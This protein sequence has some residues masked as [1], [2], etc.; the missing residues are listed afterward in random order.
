MKTKEIIINRTFDAPRELIWKAWTNPELAMRW[1]GP[2]DFTAPFIKVDLRIGGR[3]LFCMRSPEGKDYWST[4][5]YRELSEP[6]RI[7]CTDSFADSKGNIVPASYYGINEDFPLELD[8]TMTLEEN[9]GKTNMTLRHEGI[10]LGTMN[11][12]TEHG[13]EESFDKLKDSLV[14]S[15]SEIKV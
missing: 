15:K 12:M 14:K 2:K 8:V 9:N 3:Y 1:W 10:P 11:E 7:V 13:W 5:T 6:E 4:G